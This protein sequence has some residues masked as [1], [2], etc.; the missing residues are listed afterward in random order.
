MLLSTKKYKNNVNIGSDTVMVAPVKIGKFAITGAGSVVTK[1]IPDK[2]VVVG[3][4][5]RI[6]RKR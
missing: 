6:L 5:A 1:D 2:A 4:P 3:V